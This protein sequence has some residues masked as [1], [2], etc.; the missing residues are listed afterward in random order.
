MAPK[1]LV[2]FGRR[3]LFPTLAGGWSETNGAGEGVRTL[4]LHDGNVALCR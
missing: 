4:D 2:V 1:R 3:G